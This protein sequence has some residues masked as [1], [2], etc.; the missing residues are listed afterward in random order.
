MELVVERG[1]STGGATED[2]PCLLAVLDCLRDCLELDT[3]ADLLRKGGGVV[4]VNS[5]STALSSEGEEGN[6]NIDSTLLFMTIGLS[7]RSAIC[8]AILP[9]SMSSPWKF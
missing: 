2:S 3:V 4:D 6:L 1:L 9:Q 7:M 5:I 8:S